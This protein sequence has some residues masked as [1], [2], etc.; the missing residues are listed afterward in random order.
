MTT[1]LYNARILTMAEGF[2][3][4]W[5]LKMTKSSMP[6]RKSPLTCIGMWNATSTAI[7]FCQALKMPIPIPL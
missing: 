7:W 6:D 3:P 2:E 1:R 5:G 4:F